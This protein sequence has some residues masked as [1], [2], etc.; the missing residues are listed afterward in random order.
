MVGSDMPWY[1]PK[2][3]ELEYGH[4]NASR[5]NRKALSE[6]AAVAVTTLNS[7]RRWQ[8]I[9]LSTVED[10]CD[11]SVL[12]LAKCVGFCRGPGA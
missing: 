5:N 7:T 9:K 6:L 4:S 1:R 10:S 11:K 12:D 3:Q 8:P 2:W